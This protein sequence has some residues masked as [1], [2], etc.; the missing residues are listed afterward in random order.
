MGKTKSELDA[1]I[2]VNGQKAVAVIAQSGTVV[3]DGGEIDAT[4]VIQTES[5]LQKVVKTYSIGGGGGGGGDAV[6]GDI[7]GTLSNQTDLQN[8]L[9]GK[10]NIVDGEIDCEWVSVATEDVGYADL[11]PDGLDIRTG[12]DLQAFVHLEGAGGSLIEVIDGS[13]ETGQIAIRADQTNGVGITKTEVIGINQFSTQKA[14]FEG[15]EELTTTSVQLVNGNIYNGAELASVTFTLPA[16]VPVNFTA[17]L[18]FTSGTTATVLSAP[19]TVNFVGDDCTG[20][21]FTPA[22]NKRYQVLIDSDGVNIN[23]YVIG[24]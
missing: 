6:W 22:A 8:A 4:S 12:D 1:N 3:K 5:G 14:V 7:S 9:N 15:V 19:N 21:S 10:A 23:A 13:G 24:R 20:G 11:S 18:N 17:Q 2:V 16:T